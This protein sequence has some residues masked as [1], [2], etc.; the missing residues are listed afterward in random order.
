VVRISLL[1]QVAVLRRD[2]VSPPLVSQLVATP[3]ASLMRLLVAD[4]P[5]PLLGILRRR[6]KVF[7]P[8][9]LLRVCPV[10]QGLRLG[11]GGGR[12]RLSAWLQRRRGQPLLTIGARRQGH[13]VPMASHREPLSALRPLLPSRRSRRPRPCRRNS[14]SNLLDP[15]QRLPFRRKPAVWPG[16]L[17]VHLDPHQQA[18]RRNSRACR[19]RSPSVAPAW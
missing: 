2:L 4:I 8:E 14:R 10:L 9:G 3:V 18:C 19:R 12:L 11:P 6:R 5:P 13:L 7:L 17:A 1:R 15:L 16:R